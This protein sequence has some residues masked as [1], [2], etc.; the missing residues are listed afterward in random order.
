VIAR[1]VSGR[2]V[3]THVRTKIAAAGAVLYAVSCIGFALAT[4]HPLAFAAAVV[5][6]VGGAFFWIAVRAIA[7]EYLDRDSGSLAGLL[8]SEALVSWFFWIPAMR[9]RGKAEL[10]AAPERDQEVHQLRRSSDKGRG[11]ANC[12]PPD[13]LY[14]HAPILGARS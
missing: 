1:P 8:Q 5:S 14:A 12:P 11:G 3:D 4:S 13:R 6:G 7:A 9:A 2:L 10:S